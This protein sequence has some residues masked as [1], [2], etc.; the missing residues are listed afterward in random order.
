MKDYGV[1]VE[2]ATSTATDGKHI[3]GFPMAHVKEG[4]VGGGSWR[5]R[6][7]STRCARTTA[8]ARRRS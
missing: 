2:V 7:T 3:G 5:R 6:S 1:D 8:N 4:R